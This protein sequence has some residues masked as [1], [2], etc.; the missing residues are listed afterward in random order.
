MRVEGSM[1]GAKG[2]AAR[3][4]PGVIGAVNTKTLITRE[5]YIIKLSAIYHRKAQTKTDLSTS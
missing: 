2:W 5:P 3:G 4:A 1:Y